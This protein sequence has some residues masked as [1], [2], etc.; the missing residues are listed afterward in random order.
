[1]QKAVKLAQSVLGVTP[2]GSTESIYVGADPDKA[3]QTYKNIAQAGKHAK[4]G[5][6]L[7]Y[8][9]GRLIKHCKVKVE[10]P[11]PTVTQ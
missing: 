1:M 3:T 10:A 7:W 6:I 5:C 9:N 2:S 4:Y 8:G 11:E